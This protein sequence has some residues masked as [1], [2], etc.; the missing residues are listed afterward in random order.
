MQHM[1][2]HME[3][4][5]AVHCSPRKAPRASLRDRAFPSAEPDDR[6]RGCPPRISRSRISRARRLVAILCAILLP[7][8][9]AGCGTTGR[10]STTT[11][12]ASSSALTG[13][14]SIFVPSDPI[15]LSQNVPVGTWA[16]FVPEMTTL[17]VKEGFSKKSI[18]T[19]TS[20]T[21]AEQS[22]TIQDAVVKTMSSSSSKSSSSESMTLIVA[23][24]PE[25]TTTDIH[26]GDFLSRPYP[27]ST[28]TASQS[29]ET[30]QAL[31]RLSDVLQLAKQSGMHVVLI[32]NSIPDV[33]PDLFVRMSSAS[34]IGKMQAR[35][36]VEKL[37][38]DSATSSHPRVIE[39]LLPQTQSEDI[40]KA[41]FSGIWSVLKP[42]FTSGK[43]VSASKTLTSSTTDD[44]WKSVSFDAK[45]ASAS[46]DE[47]YRR[48]HHDDSDSAG[49]TTPRI[50]GI[51]ASNDYVAS[52][53][54]KK[55]T[56]MGYTGSAA[57]I[58]PSITVS[59]IVEGIIGKRD[60]QRSPV[61]DPSDAPTDEST[62]ENDSQWPI[63]TGY[64]ANVSTLP[65]VVNG[66]LWMTTVEDRGSAATLLAQAC[67][68]MDRGRKPSSVEGVD[69]GNYYDSKVPTID[70]GLVAVSATNLK[71][72]LID[73]GYVSLAD[74]GL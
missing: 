73:P 38:L 2:Q 39:V 40:D 27:D 35:N 62:E 25:D 31:N 57:Q 44:D 32:S 54:V 20:S 5:F 22:S 50:D 9:V 58:N 64:G 49:V 7:L 26:F 15:E 61:P 21:L 30:V 65:S 59:G 70:A 17:L 48:L 37:R 10:G 34:A 67:A 12:S 4:W 3:G 46:G 45:S 72:A 60:L 53:V 1:M 29:Q 16:K 42:Y 74:A 52:G 55:L 19:T 6:M 13:R 18:S 36:L 41:V 14:V 23:P 51:I 43:A 68:T 24:V 8:T 47:I 11:P 66:H 56:T 63:I 28:S 33:T 71:A 69:S